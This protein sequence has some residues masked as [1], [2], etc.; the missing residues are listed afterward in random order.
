[1]TDGHPEEGHADSHAR[2]PRAAAARGPACRGARPTRRLCGYLPL[3]IGIIA[4]QLRRHPT[5]TAERVAA[6]LAAAQDRLAVM[7]AEDV[8][9]VSSALKCAITWHISVSSEDRAH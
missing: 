2:I 1:V 5:W 9:A 8:S 3:A 4:S 7:H 6:E